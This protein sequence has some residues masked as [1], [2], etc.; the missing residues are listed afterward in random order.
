MIDE[1]GL[2]ARR[3]PAPVYTFTVRRK[4][5]DYEEVNSCFVEFTAHHVVFRND[6]GQIDYALHVSECIDIVQGDHS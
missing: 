6:D 1:T 3:N 2:T 4:N 5:G